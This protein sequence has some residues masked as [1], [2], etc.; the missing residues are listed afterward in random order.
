MIHYHFSRLRVFVFISGYK[1]EYEHV[2]NIQK[3][4]NINDKSKYSFPFKVE[5]E[6]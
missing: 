5:L 2:L 4:A 3:L 1:M 6:K